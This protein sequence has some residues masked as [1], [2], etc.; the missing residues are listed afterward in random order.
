MF[1]ERD[2]RL[3]KNYVSLYIYNENQVYEK[4]EI[5]FWNLSWSHGKRASGRFGWIEIEKKAPSPF[6]FPMFSERDFRLLKSCVSLYIYNENQVYKKS[7]KLLHFRL[8]NQCLEYLKSEKGEQIIRFVF[9]K[10][11]F[12]E[13]DF[14]H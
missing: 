11:M 12:G 3:L 6:C 13:R 1:G 10:P 14:R 8:Q 9:I 2:F 4:S 7:K 5:A